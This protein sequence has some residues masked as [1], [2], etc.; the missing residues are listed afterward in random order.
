MQILSSTEGES[1]ADEP[2]EEDDLAT[3]RHVPERGEDIE[4]PDTAYD[5]TELAEGIEVPTP[6]GTCTPINE[7]TE[8]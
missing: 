4:A 6:G 3:G 1:Y 5:G 2:E 8:E 7:G